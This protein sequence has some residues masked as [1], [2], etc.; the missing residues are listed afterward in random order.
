[1]HGNYCGRA[2]LDLVYQ[3][4]FILQIACVCEGSPDGQVVVRITGGPTASGHS[5]TGERA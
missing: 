3:P 2:L 4:N 5:T 1:M